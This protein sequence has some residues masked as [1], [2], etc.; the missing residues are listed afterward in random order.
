MELKLAAGVSTIVSGTVIKIV[1]IEADGVIVQH[2]DSRHFVRVGD[3]MP[4]VPEWTLTALLTS[5]PFVAV[6]TKK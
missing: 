2:S 4:G 5:G 1:G 6:I 3:E